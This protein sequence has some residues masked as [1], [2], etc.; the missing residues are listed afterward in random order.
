MATGLRPP[1][2]APAPGAAGVRAR[3]GDSLPSRRGDRGADHGGDVPR[4]GA[5]GRAARFRQRHVDP[6]ADA[7]DL[8]LGT[9]RA[10]APRRPVRDLGAAAEPRLHLRRGPHSGARYRPERGGVR[11]VVPVVSAGAAAHRG[12]G[13]DSPGVAAA[14]G[15]SQRPGSAHRRGH[16]ERQD[17]LG[18]V[19]R[20]PRRPRPVHCRGRLYGSGAQ[21][22]RARPGRRGTAGVLGHG[23]LLR[24]AWRSSRA[25]EADRSRGRRPRGDTGRRDR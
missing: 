5:C 10:P 15:R 24:V 7:R 21:A 18:R 17:G 14:A 11:A 4:A 13:R 1:A 12:P 2:H 3:R 23:G 6:R 9:R 25:R 19:Q 8:G 22:E 16:R 20:A